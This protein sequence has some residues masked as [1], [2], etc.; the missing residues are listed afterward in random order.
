MYWSKTLIPTL[1]ENPQEAE[2]A[3]HQ[4]MLRA[5]LMRMLISGVYFYTFGSMDNGAVFLYSE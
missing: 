5:G 3:S 1:K 2:S 4:L